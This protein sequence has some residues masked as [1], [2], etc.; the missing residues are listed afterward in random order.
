M[1][2]S[3]INFFC[4]FTPSSNV[5]IRFLFFGIEVMLS[6]FVILIFIWL[7]L[8]VIEYASF[9]KRSPF[10]KTLKKLWLS[11][12]WASLNIKSINETLG[13]LVFLVSESLKLIIILSELKL[14]IVIITD[15]GLS[16]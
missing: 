1:N 6:D 3:D 15:E 16:L 8:Y 5:T 11:I 2:S 4:L 13:S 7:W 12:F 14:F 10:I 9:G